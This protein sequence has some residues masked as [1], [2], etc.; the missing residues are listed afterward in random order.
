MLTWL[1]VKWLTMGYMLSVAGSIVLHLFTNPLRLTVYSLS[2]TLLVV[3]RPH[4]TEGPCFIP[5]TKNTAAVP[6]IHHSMKNQN[7]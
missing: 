5:L 4:H 3:L 2:Q 7:T 1:V 6:K